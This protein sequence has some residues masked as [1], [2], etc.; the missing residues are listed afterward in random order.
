MNIRFA[1]ELLILLLFFTVLSFAHA[2]PPV[3]S[4]VLITNVT[5]RSF[6]LI[7]TT[8]QSGQASIELYADS[9]AT[10]PISQ[11][12]VELYPVLTGEP[13][14]SGQARVASI[15]TITQAAQSFGIVKLQ[16][17]GLNPDT[18]YYLKYGLQTATPES[19][20]CPDAGLMFCPDAPPSLLTVQTASTQTRITPT[21]N[22]LFEN[23]IA[24]HADQ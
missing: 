23:D 24:V 4:D 15:S 8:D 11:Y 9:A 20:L 19:S 3:L 6:S 21:A 12:N 16:V 10:S 18:N 17:T 13:G 2:A 1:F 22:I 5:D 14:V 7:W